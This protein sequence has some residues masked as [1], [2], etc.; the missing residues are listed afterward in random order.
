MNMQSVILNFLPLN[1]QEQRE[2]EQA[3]GSYSQYFVG[4]ITQRYAMGWKASLD[5]VPEDVRQ[6]TVAV[7]GNIK[8]ESLRSLPNLRWLQTWSAGVDAYLVPTVACENVT[9]T[10][11]TGV[12]GQSVAEH[13]VAS[14]WA[15]MRN[16]P[17]YARQQ[18]QQQWRDA[19]AAISPVGATAVLIGTGDIGSYAA[20]L[21]KALGMRTIGVRRNAAKPADGIDTMVSFAE[22]DSVLPKADVVLLSVPSTAQ[23]HHLLNVKRL[24]LLP[25]HAIVVNAGRGDAIDPDALYEALHSQ[26]LRAAA[27]DVTEPEPLPEKSPL[28]NEPNCLI[29]PHVAGGNHLK[30]TAE[31]IINI[32]LENMRRF[33]AGEPLNN[34]V[35]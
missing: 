5:D 6:Q 18:S 33:A 23:T 26:K 29:T 22:L 3:S 35:K 25:E 20:R 17:T 32:A 13:M 21:C 14:M 19:G 15:L 2:F 10:N 9:I 34:R 28:W 24:A 12:Y 4:Q 16:L 27:L 30:E 8:P 7:I 11:A 1:E 31:H